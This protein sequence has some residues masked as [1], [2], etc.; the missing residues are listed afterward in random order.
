[1]RAGIV[2]LPLSPLLNAQVAEQLV[3]LATRH[4]LLNNIFAN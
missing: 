3:A 1:M 4:W 2:L